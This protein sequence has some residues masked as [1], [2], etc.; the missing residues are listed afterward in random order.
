MRLSARTVLAPLKSLHLKLALG[1]KI[2]LPHRGIEPVSA[3]CRSDSVP[4]TT[5]TTTT[6]AAAAAAI[7]TTTTENLY[8]ANPVRNCV[9]RCTVTH[10][11]RARTRNYTD[12]H[13]HW[14]NINI[15]LYHSIHLTQLQAVS[16]T[17]KSLNRSTLKKKRAQT[18]NPPTPP[19]IFFKG[20]TEDYTTQRSNTG[21]HKYTRCFSL[22]YWRGV[23]LQKTWMRR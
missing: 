23:F 6:T 7:T 13:N 9:K 8:S 10:S 16:S 22:T 5:T 2:R 20:Q 11:D 12:T 3:E 18:A 21:L 1:E 17:V 19:P 14:I 15:Q 4:T